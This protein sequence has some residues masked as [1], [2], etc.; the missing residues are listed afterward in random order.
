MESGGGWGVRHWSGLD[1]VLWTVVITAWCSHGHQHRLFFKR[2]DRCAG[3]V[4]SPDLCQD[5]F[6]TRG[7]SQCGAEC[8]Q[9]A[10]CLS[11]VWDPDT[12]ICRLCNATVDTQ[13]NNT[14]PADRQ[15]TFEMV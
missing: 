4:L 15:Q 5:G 13:C 8:G 9:R 12:R 11:F 7:K 2:Q 6:Q 3:Q 10:G 1:L 14:H